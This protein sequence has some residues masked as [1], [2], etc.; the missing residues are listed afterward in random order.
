[1]ARRDLHVTLALDPALVEALA[2]YRAA[3]ARLA[4]ITPCVAVWP[5][6]PPGEDYVG[7]RCDLLAGH[8]GEHRHR[9]R[10]SRTVVTW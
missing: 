2:N 1:M 7:T 4:S 6:D 8:D 5:S 10:G 3:L 9:M